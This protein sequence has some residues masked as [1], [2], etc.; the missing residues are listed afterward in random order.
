M[1]IDDTIGTLMRIRQAI[2]RGIP[3]TISRPD[4]LIA[5]LNE[6][7][8]QSVEN[9]EFDELF[10]YSDVGSPSITLTAH[11]DVDFN[12]KS[13]MKHMQTRLHVTPPGKTDEI[14][15]AGLVWSSGRYDFVYDHDAGLL[16]V[17]H[18]YSHQQV[19][20][21]SVL[22]IVKRMIDYAL[23]YLEE[24]KTFAEGGAG[25]PQADREPL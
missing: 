21:K 12:L 25:G 15:R 23:D 1:N 4:R 13:A 7:Y 2:E 24:V 10:E 5:A 17:S 3:Q 19:D 6:L 11:I 14:G 20:T 18:K 16:R 9:R 22:S 8:V